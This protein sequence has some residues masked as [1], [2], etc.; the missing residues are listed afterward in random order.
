MGFNLLGFLSD[1]G[2][3]ISAP[4]DA[5]SGLFNSFTGLSDSWKTMTGRGDTSSVSQAKNLMDYQ[6]QNQ[7]N[8]MQFGNDLQVAQWN[9]ENAY[10][11]P[12]A[13][14]ERLK[15]AGLNPLFH[16]LDGNAA[17]G[18]SAVSSPSAPDLGSIL[19]AV[20]ATMQMR[21]QQM[22]TR[23]QVGLIDA[24]KEKVKAETENIKTQGNIQKIDLDFRK[25]DKDFYLSGAFGVD[26]DGEQYDLIENASAKDSWYQ[27]YLFVLQAKT[28]QLGKDVNR[29]SEDVDKAKR[30]NRL[31]SLR[32][33]NYVELVAN[34]LRRSNADAETAEWAA[35]QAQVI[36]YN[37]ITEGSQMKLDLSV[38]SDVKETE[39]KLG[40]VGDAVRI[41]SHAIRGK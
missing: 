4:L 16:G 33:R 38:D 40:L 5:V 28:R 19:N 17:G 37:L 32:E 25:V 7:K 12:S 34:E 31:E 1:L 18:L 20:G 15:Q 35:K 2:N 3:A 24:E 39:R 30:E 36:L 14:L 8:L 13:Q 23:A 9:R 11:H 26:G 29:L 22:Q 21:F 27:P 41:I 6:M 10:N